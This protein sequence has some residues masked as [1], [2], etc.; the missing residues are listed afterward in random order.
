MTE[1]KKA[2]LSKIKTIKASDRK[3]MADI[4]GQAK[5][6]DCQESFGRFLKSLPDYLKATEFLDTA[7]RISA[8]KRANK[9]LI[10]MMGAHP[11]KVGLTPIIIDLIESGFITHVALNGAGAIH[12]LE[13]A[14]FGR[15]SE[16]VS[17]GLSDGSFG[18]VE[19]TPRLFFEAVK[20]A[21]AENLGLG[22]GLGKFIAQQS[23]KFAEHSILNAC[24]EK[25][26]PATVHVAIGTDTISQ[27]PCF[28]GAALGRLSQDDFLIL[29]ESVAGLTRGVVLNI[30]SAVIMPEVFLKALTVAR[31]IH[32]AVENFL[33]VNLDM[34][35]HYR[36]NTNVVTR[37]VAG[38]GTG[39][40]FT[41]HHEIMI[42]LLAAAIKE[43]YRTYAGKG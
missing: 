5:V 34:I 16:E 19:E 1:H 43:M 18:M 4:R 42:P 30:G 41:G 21:I 32:G 12:D 40:S 38:G 2:D 29:C 33:A 14:F 20:M 28:D 15:T 10:W 13:M 27:H 36:P 3:T 11:I 9:S 25:G 8:A 26:I 39:Y 22:E 31:N 6:F 24:H 35:Q 17:D 37:P 23:P 7:S